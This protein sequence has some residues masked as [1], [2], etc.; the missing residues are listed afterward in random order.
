MY[1]AQGLAGHNAFEA[2][3]AEG[4]L[5]QGEVALGFHV[6]LAEAVEVAGQQVVGVEFL[7]EAGGAQC[8]AQA[9]EEGGF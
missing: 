5:A 4:E 8:L 6:A 3:D 1:A 9:G 2:L 7:P